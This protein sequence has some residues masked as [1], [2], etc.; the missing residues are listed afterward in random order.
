MDSGISHSSPYSTNVYDEQM[1]IGMQQPLLF[2]GIPFHDDMMSILWDTT[3]L[4]STSGTSTPCIAEVDTSPRLNGRFAS[5]PSSPPNEASEEDKWPYRWNPESAG[6]TAAKPIHLPHTH[7]LRRGHSA[8]FDISESRRARLKSYLLE[9]RQRGLGFHNLHLP[10]LETMNIFIEIF[11]A[12]FEHQMPVIHRPSLRSSDDLPDAL[13]AA[14]VAIGAIYSRVKHTSRFAIVLIDMA[15]LSAQLSLELNNKLMRDPMFVYALALLC[16]AGLWCGNK[17]LF[18]LAENLRGT[19]VTYARHIQRSELAVAQEDEQRHGTDLEG[20]WQL[21]IQ[22]ESRKRLS[23]CI[24]ALDC[25][26]PCLLY[27]PTSLSLAEFMS[28]ECPCDEEYWHASTAYSWKSLLGSASVPPSRT[29]ISAGRPFLGPLDL[30]QQQQGPS[31]SSPLFHGLNPWTRYLVLMTI[32]VQVFELSQQ[33]TMVSE[34]TRD[35]DTW[36]SS[37]TALSSTSPSASVLALDPEVQPHLA[38]MVTRCSSQRHLGAKF[39]SSDQEMLT[40]LAQRRLRVESM[41]SD[42]ILDSYF[43][44]QHLLSSSFLFPNSSLT[45][46]LKAWEHSFASP[47]PPDASIYPAS[48][49][50]HA[51]SL[52]LL[53]LGRLSLHAPISDLQN[54]LGKAGPAEILPAMERM[55]QMLKHNTHQM[56]RALDHCLQSVDNLQVKPAPNNQPS[57]VNAPITTPASTTTSTQQECSSRR[58]RDP[59]EIITC[60]LSEILVWMLVHCA[61]G[62][63]SRVLR[64]NMQEGNVNAIGGFFAAVAGALDETIRGNNTN[65]SSGSDGRRTSRASSVLFA[66]A[67]V[68]SEMAPWTA[69]LN[70]ALLLCHRGKEGVGGGR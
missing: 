54:A 44:G 21:W 62:A 47:P 39:S 64:E 53:Q 16:Y 68:L 48:H 30:A 49:H 18:E 58:T 19:V 41:S 50:F 46:M 17:R 11:F 20:Q 38:Y 34:A 27:L 3:P 14:I 1:I 4:L 36:Q 57:A 7:S 8:Q 33:I 45:E 22:R 70:L 35:P 2:D 10:D 56:A 32:L 24:Y 5:R 43:I 6:I 28:K 40:S 66:A 60:F 26:F 69:S 59:S 23:W 42:P 37:E 51:T 12:Q 9:P 52:V 25:T 13:L 31:S 15:R 29:F 67:D 61:D 63:Q 65:N 55:T